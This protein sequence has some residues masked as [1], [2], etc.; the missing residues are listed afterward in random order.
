MLLIRFGL[1]PNILGPCINRHGPR[2]IPLNIQVISPPND[3]EHAPLAPVA[4]PGVSH[5]PVL[6]AILLSPPQHRHLV[7]PVH[8]TRRVDEYPASVVDELVGGCDAAGDW[9]A[10]VDLVHH[11]ILPGN[12]PILINP[13]D[14]CVRLRPAPLPGRTVL[15]LDHIRALQ[16]RRIPQS[17]IRCTGLISNVIFMNPPVSVTGVATMAPIVPLIT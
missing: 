4:S 9:A 7:I 17:L 11:G 8:L 6:G 16:P 14:L 15:A 13:I 10:L 5:F 12:I 1:I 3:S 2:A